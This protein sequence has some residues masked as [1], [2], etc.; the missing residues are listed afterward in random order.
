MGRLSKH[1]WPMSELETAV[2]MGG[3]ARDYSFDFDGRVFKVYWRQDVEDPNIAERHL[4][5]IHAPV[6]DAFVQVPAGAEFIGARGD[7]YCFRIAN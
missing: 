2:T 4:R 3:T 7:C 1:E 5:V 6:G